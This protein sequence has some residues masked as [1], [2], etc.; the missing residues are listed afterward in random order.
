ME[1]LRRREGKGFWL[2]RLLG[3][4]LPLSGRLS[5]TRFYLLIPDKYVWSKWTKSSWVLLPPIPPQIA[6][7]L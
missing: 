1:S 2:S 5:R 4:L 3:N 7:N 6:A